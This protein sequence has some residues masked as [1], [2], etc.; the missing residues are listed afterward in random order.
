MKKEVYVTEG[1]LRIK[2]QI[3]EA[4]KKSPETD[5]S[6]SPGA[7]TET[8]SPQEQ[9]SPETREALRKRHEEFTRFRR[10]VLFKVHELLS[11]SSAAAGAARKKAEDSS[12]VETQLKDLL[13]RIEE[14]GEPDA[15]TS[16]YQIRLS[17]ACRSLDRLRLDLIPLQTPL[18]KE[19]VSSAESAPRSNFFAELDSVSFWQILRVG[20]YLSLPLL[21]AVLLFG[22]LLSIVIVMTFRIGL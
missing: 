11:V 2:G 3:A 16:D 15:D 1:L 17:V 13:T 14:L 7:G 12:L 4:A 10:D 22:A 8:V 5:V 6:G 19:Q 18:E 20:L 9:L 21:I